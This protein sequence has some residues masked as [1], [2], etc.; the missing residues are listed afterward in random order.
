MSLSSTLVTVDQGNYGQSNNSQTKSSML[1]Y[2]K[3]IEKGKK[4]LLGTVFVMILTGIL[5]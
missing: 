5:L 2:Y 1:R 4:V 3:E